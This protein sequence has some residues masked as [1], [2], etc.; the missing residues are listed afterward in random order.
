ML[1]FI[2][3]VILPLSIVG[4]H[5]TVQAINAEEDIHRLNYG[6]LFQKQPSLY[7][8]REYWLHTFEVEL[9]S[10]ISI[11]SIPSCTAAVSTCYLF[12]SI[13][14]HV[15]VLKENTMTFTHRTL[16]EIF[17][18][19][20]ET[21][22]NPQKRKSRALLPFIGSLSKS[23]FGTATMDDVNLLA[24]H[25]NKLIKR[26]RQMSHALE[27]HGSHISS[28][29]KVVS[30]RFDKLKEG[31]NLNHILANQILSSN[32]QFEIL[33]ANLS[34]VAFEQISKANEIQVQLVNTLSSI[35]SL[36]NGKI[37]PH[38]IPEHVLKKT[39]NGILDILQRDYPKFHLL[40]NKPSMY[41]Q[42][43]KFFFT[44]HHS[45]LYITM[46]FPISSFS[47]AL[48]LYQILS[49]PHPISQKNTTKASQILDLPT[50]VAITANHRHYTTFNYETLYNC[51]FDRYITCD[52]SLPI[53]TI[54]TSSCIFA[55]LHDN[56]SVIFDQ[57]NF[58]LL[59]EL[60][61]PNI[62]ELSPASILLTNAKEVTLKCPNKTST[63]PGCQ[64]CIQNIP[65]SCTLQTSTITYHPRLVNCQEKLPE[66]TRLYPINL[67]L[68]H[69]FF[70]FDKVKSYFGNTYF[71]TAINIS[72][73][74]FKFYNHKFNSILASDIKDHLNL[75]KIAKSAKKDE[76]IFQ[77]LAEPL[78]DGQITLDSNWPDT[79]GYLA[80]ASITIGGISFIGFVYMFL[81]FRSLRTSLLILQQVYNVHSKS[82]VPSFLFE[83]VT[84][85]TT[86]SFLDSAILKEFTWVHGSLIVGVLI[87][88]LL[89]CVLVCLFKHK[90]HNTTIMLE[91]TSG[92]SC[93]TIPVTSFPLCPSYWDIQPPVTIQNVQICNFPFGKLSVE[94]P[95]FKVINKL[96]KQ[97]LT[98]KT[99]FKVGLFNYF[100][101][102]R[103]INQPYCAYILIVHQGL[104]TPL[105]ENQEPLIPKIPQYQEFQNNLYPNLEPY[106]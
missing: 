43:A 53:Q 65:C 74:N 24:N 68:L 66:S 90:S 3:M 48:T 31:M 103:I 60:T 21:N 44:R 83:A 67:A 82:T 56:K 81:Q 45:R 61:K 91:I 106:L 105:Q 33:M 20:P 93:A 10:N 32:K 46:K 73:P 9:P 30:H 5:M 47:S 15:N 37:T 92:G 22:L 101:I 96:T 4:G 79:N 19:V 18:M 25:I 49:F 72:I 62:F 77:N 54:K 70:G 38:L 29:M 59:P 6:V 58:R 100:K 7:L 75:K 63:L 41:Y 84:Q 104:A 78:L 85:T 2:V 36:I 55:L 40:Q 95:G 52:V 97:S 89:I 26:D 23:F 99:C 11:Q 69:A 87:L 102:R 50:Y 42:N 76:T 57:C 14:F 98:V 27:Q 88:I 34:M 28:F 80:I 51:E 94:W 17:D 35:Q 39:I 86:Q 16:M 12:N 64:F 1:M 71:K 8:S 13:I